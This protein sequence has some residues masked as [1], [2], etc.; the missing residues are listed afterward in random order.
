MDEPLADHAHCPVGDAFDG[1]G[2]ECPDKSSPWWWHCDCWGWPRSREAGGNCC[3]CD[4][5]APDP[6]NCPCARCK[7]VREAVL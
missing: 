7:G 1:D 4:Q 3:R 6:A 2:S 5:V